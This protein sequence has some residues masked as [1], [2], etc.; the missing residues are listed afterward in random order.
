MTRLSEKIRQVQ[1]L[2]MIF[3]NA[4]PEL[5]SHLECDRLAVYRFNPDWVG[6]LLPNP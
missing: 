3:R 5:R 4:L 2:E 6:S 1:E